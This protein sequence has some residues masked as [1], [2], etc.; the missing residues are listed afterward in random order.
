MG[1]RRACPCGSSMPYAQCCGRLH[2]GAAQAE[3]AEQLMRSRYSAF[4]LGETDYLLRSWHPATR[5]PQLELDPG[6]RWQRLEILSVADGGPSDR[7]GTV[8]FRAHY[9]QGG[10]AG[11]LHEVSRFV[12]HDDAWVYVQGKVL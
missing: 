6:L 2:E 5:P 3:T 4:A 10:Q 7:K 12:R 9:V 8:E 1:K 11:E